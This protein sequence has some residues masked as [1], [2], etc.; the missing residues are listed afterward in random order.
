[1]VLVA[2]STSNESK[3]RANDNF[4]KY[5]QQQSIFKPLTTGDV[6]LPPQD[7]TFAL[8]ASLDKNIH[9]PVDIRPPSTP[10]AAINY[11]IAQFDGERALIAYPLDKKEIYSLNQ[12]GRLLKEQGIT[13]HQVN[14]NQI[15]TNWT[16]TGRSDDIE[17]MQI[18]YLIEQVSSK[19]ASALAVS[20]LQIKRDN[21]IFTPTKI[22]KQRYASDCLNKFVGELN[23][24]Y[25]KQQGELYNAI[26]TP[27]S[28]QI[29]TDINDRVVLALDAGFAQSWQRLRG[30]LSQLGFEATEENAGRGYREL[31]YTP[32][33]NTEWARFGVFD[34]KLE[35]GTYSMQ[36]LALGKQSAVVISD[37]EG[38]AIAGKQAQNIYQALQTI[39][40]R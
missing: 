16:S 7:N 25:R 24:T 19:D 1:M 8:P 37:E 35:K 15:E 34:P 14:A 20:I 39:L 23:A 30:A 21:I 32:L 36:L 38:K 13:Y 12:V 33:E 6:H 5:I 9:Q 29:T 28:S 18:R 3:Q 22:Q 31:K 17:D 2:C 27:I 26:S 11:S 40:A 10:I 4:D